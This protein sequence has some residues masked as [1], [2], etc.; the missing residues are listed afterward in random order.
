MPFI[1]SPKLTYPWICL[2]WKEN[3][4]EVEKATKRICFS[5]QFFHEAFL[6]STKITMSTEQQVCNELQMINP[7]SFLSMKGDRQQHWVGTISLWFDF[8]EAHCW[9]HKYCAPAFH[10]NSSTQEQRERGHQ[11]GLSSVFY[12]N[13]TIMAKVQ[14]TMTLLQFLFVVVDLPL[15]LYNTAPMLFPPDTEILLVWPVAVQL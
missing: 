4:K 7:H 6:L 10:I 3:N 5:D 14:I 2:L 9:W 12:F 8:Q 11:L 1:S 13:A 15:I